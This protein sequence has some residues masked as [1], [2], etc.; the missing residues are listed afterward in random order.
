M[1]CLSI[2]ARLT[3]W[4][5]RLHHLHPERANAVHCGWGWVRWMVGMKQ[6][7]QE[8]GPLHHTDTLPR[9]RLRTFDLF[10][11]VCQSVTPWTLAEARSNPI[12]GDEFLGDLQQRVKA[13]CGIH[14]FSIHPGTG[15]LAHN[16]GQAPVAPANLQGTGMSCMLVSSLPWLV[17]RQTGSCLRTISPSPPSSSTSTGHH[18]HNFPN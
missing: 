5:K 1:M 6:W 14:P 17:R 11:F 3:D 2:R 9:L 4:G 12:L 16:T 10:L 15:T 13:P 18:V 8:R 7:Q